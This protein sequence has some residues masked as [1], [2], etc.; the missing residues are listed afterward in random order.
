[1][2]KCMKCC[3]AVLFLGTILLTGPAGAQGAY[4]VDGL[5]S[6]YEAA[7]QYI[8][9]QT[10]FTGKG[11]CFV[12]GAGQGRLAYE[13]T[14]RSDLEI[15]GVEG[16]SSQ[17]DIGREIL[18][19]EGVYGSKITLHTGSLNSILKYRDYSAV[20]VVSDSIIANGTC[21]G[22]ASE[23]YRMARPA[24]GVVLIGQ[25]VGC[26]NVLSRTNLE[27]WLDAGGLN[28]SY[29]IVENP[30][31][32]LWAR[33]DRGP[34]S[35]AGEWTMQWGNLG[36]TACSG[37]EGITD[38]W[39]VL[40]YGEPGPRVIANR[41]SRGATD[42]YKSGKWI[43][44]GGDRV[45]CMDAY[46]GARLWD[47]EVTDSS[48][49]A[50]NHDCGWFTLDDDYVFVAAQDDCHKVDVE[51]GTITDTYHP[52][53]GGRDWGYVAV[54]GDLLYGSEQTTNASVIIEY[55]LDGWNYSHLEYLPTVT[56]KALFC[57]NRNT[58]ALIWTYD[59][60]D[61][62][63][64]NPFVIANPT[65]CADDDYFYFFES[66]NPSAVS[67]SDGR[68]L[69]SDFT[70]GS[71]EYLV[72]LNRNTGV[73]QWRL[74]KELTFQHDIYLSCANGMLLASGSRTSSYYVY[75]FRAYDASDGSLVW[76]DD[77]I[78]SGKISD[79]HGYHDKHPM[80][81]GNNVY[82][83]Y[84]SYNLLTGSSLGF[85]WEL[86]TSHCADSCAS[87]T[88]F[89]TRKVK[90]GGGGATITSFSG[91]ASSAQRLSEVIR[92]HCYISMIPVG[93]LILLPPFGS[94]CTC[95]LALQPTIAWLPQ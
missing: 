3:I 44:P 67:D 50:I 80:I 54:D 75:D 66:Y 11:Y 2:A 60:S 55:H 9:D 19:D 31:D 70:N 29:S 77:G 8:I 18:L 57:R 69:L 13:L 42:Q 43:I 90:S 30:T 84:K 88:H 95:D 26:P 45:I 72:K 21:T 63:G 38:D 47:L 4:P 20:L 40:W 39:T 15:I 92:P 81:V 74:Q 83:K 48:R 94:G 78:S 33:I 64:S 71:N 52:P 25:P 58:G 91:G 36:N 24:G 61:G 49:I 10:G 23:M 1:M 6:S 5:T 41:H 56:S 62:I 16:D 79:N 37:E 28:G 73:V 87:M 82:F 27:A 53:T 14:A 68:V 12:F 34:L 59:S 46:N 17:V 76:S 86:G 89:F 93:G 7:A 22:Y 85:T 65:I 51:T 35:G 32:G